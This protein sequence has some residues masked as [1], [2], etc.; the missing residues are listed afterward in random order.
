MSRLNI[1]PFPCKEFN[2]S[3]TKSSETICCWS[4]QERLEALDEKYL[5]PWLVN[6]APMSNLARL[7]DK[8][9]LDEH[10][11][12]L[13]GPAAVLETQKDFDAVSITS[14]LPSFPIYKDKDVSTA[15]LPWRPFY[16]DFNEKDVRLNE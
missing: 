6:A 5:T 2:Y 1:R 14:S 7:Y 13:Y 15:W 12:N 4:S 9:V 3:R 8:L 16:H 10:Y 11:A